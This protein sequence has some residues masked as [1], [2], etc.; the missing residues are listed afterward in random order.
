MGLKYTILRDTH[1]NS[2]IDA[3]NKHISEGWEPLG[4]VVLTESLCIQGMIKRVWGPSDKCEHFYLLNYAMGCIHCGH[5]PCT[6]TY[7][8]NSS[9]L[10]CLQCGEAKNFIDNTST[11]D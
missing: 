9:S 7:D 5:K 8:S 6:H 4:N 3:V 10:N 11:K 2:L 1:I